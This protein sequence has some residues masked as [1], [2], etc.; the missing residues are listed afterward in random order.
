M[1]NINKQFGFSAVELLITLFVA[2]MFLVTGYQLY[3][4]VIKDDGQTRAKNIANNLAREYVDKYKSSAT[5][6]C[7]QQTPLNNSSVTIANLSNVTI[8]VAITCPYASTTTLSKIL[9]TINYGSGNNSGIAN[10]ATY[11]TK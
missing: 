5:N 9:S 2:A 4:A 8:T 3:N 6:P 11:V 1:K 10:Y 7:T